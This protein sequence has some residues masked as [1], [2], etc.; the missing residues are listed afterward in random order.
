[1]RAVDDIRIGRKLLGGFGA[2]AVVALLIGAV[3]YWSVGK[4]NAGVSEIGERTMPSIDAIKTIDSAKSTMA[5]AE[6]GLLSRR[7]FAD[8]A[9]RKALM[10]QEAQA[11][12]DIREVWKAYE[13]LPKTRQEAELF[14]ELVPAWERWLKGHDAM[15]A[16]HR[17]REALMLGGAGDRDP[18]IL[19]QDRR[20]LD[21]LAGQTEDYNRTSEILG[22]LVA[23][24]KRAGAQ[25]VQ[26]AYAAGRQARLA[27]VAAMVAGVI[28]AVLLGVYLS[29]SIAVPLAR[30]LGM[31]T[32]L[33]EG[34]LSARLGMQ[35]KDEVGELARA[36]DQF[37]DDLQALVA[38][39]NRL[40][41]AAVEGKLATR[42]DVNGG[43]GAYRDIVQGVNE[44]LDAVIGPLTVAA[45]YVDR[46]S[47]GDI[48]PVITDSY[49]GDFNTIKNNLNTC[50][51][52]VNALV[53][54]AGMLSQ[55]A[56][57]GRLATRA[58]AA[59]H[60]GD[61]RKI[62]EGVN[63]TL[64]AIVGPVNEA[65]A[66][67]ER[68]AD[69]DLTARME[70][71]YRGDFARIKEA[72]NT[73][74]DNLD[75]G[76]AQVAEAAEQVAAASNQISQGSQ[77]LAHG[78]SSQ[79]ASLEEI[80][81]SLQE[82]ASMGDQNVASAE[83]ARV[84]ADQAQSSA[85]RGA[86]NMKLLSEAMSRIKASSDNTAKIVK[87]IDEI[88]FQTNLLAL[89]AAVEAARAGDA[90][91]GFAVV[92]EEVRNLAMRSA[93]AAKNTAN[94]IEES[95]KNAESGVSI[96]QGVLKDLQEINQQ[97]SSVTDVMG[98]IAG[99]SAEQRQGMHHV[100]TALE[101]VNVVTQQAA[102]N[103][104]EA[105]ASSEELLAQAEEMQGMV[106]SFQLTATRERAR[107]SDRAASRGSRRLGR[108]AA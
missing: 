97:A 23:E 81:A 76:L 18:R 62:V 80:S 70:G 77:Q 108:K 53:A 22:R 39:A 8:A 65:A 12:K 85:R 91:K 33:G 13:S 10:D 46:I 82:A 35:R 48:P 51:G 26:T 99:A 58:E 93:E 1:M 24:I 6:Y 59:K 4:V 3:G 95:V 44:T 105:A 89:N 37:A 2:V 54:D 102:A 19:A 75:S 29:R 27:I 55:A 86:D 15:M 14:E 21:A 52:A 7:V 96:N 98:E 50:I 67:L 60:H 73:A 36:M 56:V 106:G 11:Q 41:K 83:K 9:R 66:T 64:D 31:V 34:Q 43:K 61:F 78:A 40:S 69:R 68:L 28:I 87:T 74:M 38:E 72:L 107:E 20:L 45:D 5:A 25:S 49:N 84:L 30:A 94:L 90:G 57:E 92:A 42:G 32:E 88:A 101:Q 104:E 71:D 100:T 47:K 63:E 17:S 16:M 103:S 79:A